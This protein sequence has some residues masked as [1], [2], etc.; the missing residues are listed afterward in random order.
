MELR[1]SQVW[2]LEVRLR[3]MLSQKEFTTINMLA[4]AKACGKALGL[5]LRA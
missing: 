1:Y 4:R 5:G 2:K 3:P